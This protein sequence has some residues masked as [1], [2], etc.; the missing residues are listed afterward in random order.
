MART[1][2]TARASTGGEVPFL[3]FGLTR[4][5]ASTDAWA[6]TEIAENILSQLCLK[7]LLLAQRVSKS[8]RDLI[9]SSPRLQQDLFFRPR[10]AK[11][12]ADGTRTRV[13][14]PLLVEHM[15]LW[16][17]RGKNVWRQ[18]VTDVPWAETVA[19]L[20]FMRK[21]ASWRNMLITQPPLTVFE[22]VHRTHAMGGDSL[23]VGSLEQADGVRMG[24]AYDKAAEGHRG[25]SCLPGDFSTVIDGEVPSE[26]EPLSVETHNDV[27]TPKSLERV[28]GGIGKFTLITSTTIGCVESDFDEWERER[29]EQ[30]RFTSS[31][32][33]DVVMR[34][35]RVP[36]GNSRMFSWWTPEGY[37]IPHVGLENE[38]D[39]LQAEMS[40]D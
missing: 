24:L 6:I 28:F 39:L 21:E 11:G 10:E 3:P 2:Q 40:R 7:D 13:L 4:R 29:L 36:D 30:Q 9:Q 17:S 25:D 35:D 5:V 38:L 19:R 12:S 1:T 18:R 26:A 34:V 37:R 15:P 23:A 20:A 33:G 8:W 27:N 31:G 22:L 32:R 14:N 16:F